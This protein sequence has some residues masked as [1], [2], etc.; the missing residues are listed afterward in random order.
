MKTTSEER[1]QLRVDPVCGE[2]YTRLCDDVDE[3]SEALENEKN[4]R[5]ALE[6]AMAA[7]MR[8]ATP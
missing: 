4:A 8:G 5:V 3:L 1:A 7:M 2:T 6:R